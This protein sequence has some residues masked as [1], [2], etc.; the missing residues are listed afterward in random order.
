MFVDCVI[1]IWPYSRCNQ[2]HP[3]FFLFHSR[4]SAASKY[5]FNQK[6]VEPGFFQRPTLL[7]I[8]YDRCSYERY[9][10]SLIE[11]LVVQAKNTSTVWKCVCRGGSFVRPGQYVELEVNTL[12]VSRPLCTEPV[13]DLTCFS[14]TCSLGRIKFMELRYY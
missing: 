12:E 2:Y 5:S 6:M 9:N 3:P 1:S 13:R 14:L 4:L 7:P 8:V 10:K 11:K